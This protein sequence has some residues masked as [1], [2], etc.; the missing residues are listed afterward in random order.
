[1]SKLFPAAIHIH[2]L[3]SS[4]DSLYLLCS[5]PCCLTFSIHWLKQRSASVFHPRYCWRY[6]K[7]QNSW[8]LWW[9]PSQLVMGVRVSHWKD[10][11]LWYLDVQDKDPIKTLGFIK[12][13]DDCDAWFLDL[14]T[15]CNSTFIDMA[16]FLTIA[17]QTV[18]HFCITSP[19]HTHT[20]T[21]TY[22]GPLIFLRNGSWNS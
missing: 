20:H 10:T 14:A 18:N 21:H 17:P 8:M 5:Q 1:M 12:S 15:V 6:I 19:S 7:C 3:S 22:K 2:G 9:L 4:R 11:Q 13:K 16:F